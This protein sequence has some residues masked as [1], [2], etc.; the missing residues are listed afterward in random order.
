MRSAE[1]LCGDGHDIGG[2]DD[3]EAAVLATV[4]EADYAGDLGE[5]G[6]VFA[7]TYV[8]A[9]L[10]RCTALTDDDAAAQDGL[11][12]EYLNAEPLSI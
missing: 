10:E 8:E 5:E 1:K 9:G 4:L 3:D 12:A 2:V 6:V 7:A 11:S